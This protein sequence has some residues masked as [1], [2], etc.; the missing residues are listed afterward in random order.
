MKRTFRSELPRL[1]KKTILLL[2]LIVVVYSVLAFYRLGTTKMPKTAVRLDSGDSFVVKLD[3]VNVVD[4]FYVY[5]WRGMAGQH[6]TI[7]VSNDNETWHTAYDAMM[8][9]RASWWKFESAYHEPIQYVKVTVTGGDWSDST[10]ILTE[11]D[12]IDK[13]G[14][15]IY[16]AELAIFN[17][18]DEPCS[19]SVMTENIDGSLL[20][21]EAEMLEKNPSV[22]Q[23]AYFDEYIFSVTAKDY[24][25][26]PD[27]RPYEISHPAL[28]KELMAVGISMFGF[29]TLGWRLMGT[30][31]GIM[32]LPIMFFLARRVLMD[33][34]WALFAMF[35]MSVDVL[36]YTQTR[37]ATIDSYPLLFILCAYLFMMCYWQSE[38]LKAEMVSLALSGVSFGLACATKWIGCYAGVGLAIT[39][40]V[41]FG[42]K[43]AQ[44]NQYPLSVNTVNGYVW[45]IIGGCLVFFCIIP[46]VIYVASFI[47]IAFGPFKLINGWSDIFELNKYM[48][49]FH[50]GLVQHFNISSKWYDWLVM[51]GGFRTF[52]SAFP[53]NKFVLVVCFVNPLIWISVMPALVYGVIKCV[54]DVVKHCSDMGLFTI[55]VAA[56]AQLVPWLFVKRDTFLYH[57]LPT[58]T[59][60]LILIVYGLRQIANRYKIENLIM[61]DYGSVAGALCAYLFPMM[62][63]LAVSYNYV[64]WLLPFVKY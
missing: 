16:L 7:D 23:S 1:D 25:D 51:G 28:G 54:K 9:N 41:M 15:P 17:E 43:I 40:F 31:F 50:A 60:S 12:L 34:K 61:L 4:D 49:E 14:N 46:F 63:G 52:L 27:D 24:L 20:Y 44:R 42:V 11:M 39:F 47:P 53:D 36:Q 35:L 29:N 6:I 22:L 38:T 13:F 45:R 57:F 64:K 37:M 30:L 18:N 56:L 32:C 5:K 2:L 33:N 21:D 8:K 55:T 58:M 19:Y 10:R 48:F 26:G 3:D 59:L 62:N